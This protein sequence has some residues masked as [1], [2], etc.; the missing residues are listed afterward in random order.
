[1][2][3]FSKI[4]G[5]QFSNPHGLFG[6]ICCIIMNVMNKRMYR[7][8]ISHINAN[9]NSTILDIGYG[10]GYLINKLYK[11]YKSTIKGIEI[12]KDM[13]QIATRKN[14]SGIKNGKVELLEADCCNLQFEQESFDIVTSINTIYFWND[15]RK[16]LN[17]IFKVLKPDGCFYNTVYEKEWLQSLKF[18]R[19]G[20]KFFTQDDYIKLG[21]EIGFSKIEIIPIKKNKSFI[22]KYIK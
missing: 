17:E 14:K 18:T 4:I 6:K 3:K 10:N 8:V 20:F 7:T 22:I 19:E 2:S 12:S 1:M 9:E 11:R 21:E 13:E 15:E 5:K 16:G